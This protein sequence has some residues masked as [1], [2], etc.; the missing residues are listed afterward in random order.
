MK[1]VFLLENSRNL[2]LEKQEGY[3]DEERMINVVVK[4]GKK[5]PMIS[6]DK[7]LITETKTAAGPVGDDDDDFIIF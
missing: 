2:D 3:Y 7:L 5:I 4:N 6:S 1:N